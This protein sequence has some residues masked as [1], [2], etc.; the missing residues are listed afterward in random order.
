MILPVVFATFE[1]VKLQF[2]GN[3]G[4]APVQIVNISVVCFQVKL[5]KD[6]VVQTPCGQIHGINIIKIYDVGANLCHIGVVVFFESLHN[7]TD[8]FFCKYFIK[9]G[10]QNSLLVI[11]VIKGNIVAFWGAN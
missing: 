4:V 9:S 10:I 6:V 3:I 7:P 8:A 11:C 2:V 5:I 1:Q